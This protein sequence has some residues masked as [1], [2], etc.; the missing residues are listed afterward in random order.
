M[1]SDM[2]IYDDVALKP[3]A[4]QHRQQTPM[5]RVPVRAFGTVLAGWQKHR[6]TSYIASHISEKLTI[7]VL[8][9]NIRLSP[10]HFARAFKAS[11]QVAPGRYIRNCRIEVSKHLLSANQASLAEIAIDCGFSDQAHFS[12]MFRSAVGETPGRWRR[13]ATRARGEHYRSTVQ[14]SSCIEGFVAGH[15][16]RKALATEFQ[17]HVLQPW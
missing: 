12:R 7:G 8:A 11:Y 15:F 16:S 9:R 2:I 14:T 5:K 6:T 10:G 17:A 4:S 13:R 3:I 1:M